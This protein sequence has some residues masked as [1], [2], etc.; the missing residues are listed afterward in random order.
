MALS[1]DAEK[2][3]LDLIDLGYRPYH[4]RDQVLAEFGEDPLGVRRDQEGRDMTD[5]RSDPIDCPRCGNEG[6]RITGVKPV[7]IPSKYGGGWD[8]ATCYDCPDCGEF[9]QT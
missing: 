4:A 5:K 1:K 8:T 6:A 9:D 2:Y 7:K 3:Y